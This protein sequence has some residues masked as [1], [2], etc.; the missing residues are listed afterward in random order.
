M[1]FFFFFFFFKLASFDVQA[2]GLWLGVTWWQLC[3]WVCVHLCVFFFF[4]FFFFF[5]HFWCS[6]C[7]C[8]CMCVFMCSYMSVLNACQGIYLVSAVRRVCVSFHFLVPV[9]V[10]VC[11]SLFVWVANIS[12]FHCLWGKK[13]STLHP[14]FKYTTFSFSSL[15]FFWVACTPALSWYSIYLSCVF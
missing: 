9:C 4:F 15:F 7:V 13:R 12:L 8:V 14:S 6:L 10:C 11:V 5:L 3:R 2:L 1:I